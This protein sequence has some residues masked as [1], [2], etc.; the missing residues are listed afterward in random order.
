MDKSISVLIREVDAKK[1]ERDYAASK[2]PEYHEWLDLEARN[3]FHEG[4][5]ARILK[6]VTGYNHYSFRNKKINNNL[7]DE[8][9]P[10]CQ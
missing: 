2:V 9:C 4:V 1:R 3:T 6:C 10:R 8:K 5:G 7:I